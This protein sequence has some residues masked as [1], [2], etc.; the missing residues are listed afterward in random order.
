MRTNGIEEQQLLPICD[1]CTIAL[2]VPH[3]RSVR[4]VRMHCILITCRQM[5]TQLIRVECVALSTMYLPSYTQ[6]IN[7][8]LQPLGQCYNDSTWRQGFFA[9]FPLDS[10]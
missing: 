1:Q 2:I 5:I 4:Q 6:E 10:P 3:V 7:N 9:Q 8:Y